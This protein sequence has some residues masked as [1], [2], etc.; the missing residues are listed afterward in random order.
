MSAMKGLMLWGCNVYVMV[1]SWAIDVIVVLIGLILN[2]NMASADVNK[3]I[4]S[5]G[6][7][8]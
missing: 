7:N 6:H 2:G 8:V 4:H 5:M 1:L 3:A